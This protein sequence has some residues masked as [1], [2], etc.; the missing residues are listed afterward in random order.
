MDTTSF[1]LLLAISFFSAI[2]G[3]IVGMAMLI[4]LPVMIFLGVPVHTA[5]ATG[6][7]S[8]NGINLGNVSKFSKSDKIKPKY[9]M[10][11][12]I[13]GAIGS[14]IGAS[15]L[16]NINENA[17]KTIIGIFMIIVSVLVLFEDFIKSRKLHDKII[18]KH[19]FLS[20]L[21]GIFVGSY[22]GIIGG[23]GATLVIFL[24]MLVYGLSFHDAVANQ[25]AVTLPIS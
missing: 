20:G 5:V 18:Y 14:F 19:H 25:K 23:G 9:F 2:I 12:A 16:K 10:A 1:V 7:F 22:I 6:R 13:A 4:L 17:L 11:F 24:L 15:F 3:S 21:A 8:M